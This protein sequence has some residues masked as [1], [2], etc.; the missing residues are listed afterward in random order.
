MTEPTGGAV[1]QYDS[2]YVYGNVAKTSNYSDSVFIPLVEMGVIAPHYTF[3]VMQRMADKTRPE[4]VSIPVALY[5]GRPA[6]V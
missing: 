5:L 1:E 4:N 6:E 3:T 2:A